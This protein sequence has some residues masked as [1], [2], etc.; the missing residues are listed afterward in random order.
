MH[1]EAHVVEAAELDHGRKDGIAPAVEALLRLDLHVQPR[2]LGLDLERE[3]VALVDVERDQVLLQV[4]EGG[5]E[6]DFEVDSL[7]LAVPDDA[8]VVSREYQVPGSAAAT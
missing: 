6:G 7:P 4:F 8:V 3:G 2:E 5:D 1:V